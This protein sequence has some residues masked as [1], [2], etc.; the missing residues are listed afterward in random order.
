[1]LTNVK[2]LAISEQHTPHDSRAGSPDRSFSCATGSTVVNGTELARG[3]PPTVRRSRSMS[4][5]QNSW[6]NDVNGKM[7]YT[8]NYKLKGGFKGNS[9]GTS[10]QGPFTTLEEVLKKL[11][12]EVG[13]NIELS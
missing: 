8:R 13:F 10:I 5:N 7:K 11:P 3:S 12:K 9:R 2:F 6:D 1:M 4:L